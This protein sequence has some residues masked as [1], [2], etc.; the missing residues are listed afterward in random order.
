MTSSQHSRRKLTRL[1]CRAQA[2]TLPT[3]TVV[4][5]PPQQSGPGRDEHRRAEPVTASRP[6]DA[7]RRGGGGLHRER[8]VAGVAQGQRLVVDDP[9][10]PLHVPSSSSPSSPSPGSRTTSDTSA[11]QPPPV[12]ASR[13]QQPR[14]CDNDV[15]TAA[16]ARRGPAPPASRVPR[17]ERLGPALPECQGELGQGVPAAQ[18]GAAR[19]Q[20]HVADLRPDRQAR[21]YRDL[22]R[23]Q[24]RHPASGP[25]AHG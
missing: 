13:I 17:A 18:G 22:G 20:P 10:E 23:P 16:P 3:E 7:G 24:L 8:A 2:P 9:R 12:P 6:A 5:A 14:R 1:T 4:S 21:Q 25:V 15:V 11:L 19:H